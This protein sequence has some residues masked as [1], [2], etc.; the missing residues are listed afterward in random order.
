[1]F[2]IDMKKILKNMKNFNYPCYQKKNLKVYKKI[3][4]LIK[5]KLK[6]QYFQFMKKVINS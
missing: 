5:L 2:I 3:I 1:M 6:L 4:L